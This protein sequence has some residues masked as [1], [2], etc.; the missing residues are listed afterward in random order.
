MNKSFSAGLSARAFSPPAGL[1]AGTAVVEVQPK[2]T[3]A[4]APP[5]PPAPLLAAPPAP[6]PPPPPPPAE[7]IRTEK[8]EMLT[9]I[10]RVMTG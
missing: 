9:N 1:T 6:L 2:P 8:R 3:A 5:A 4:P 10:V 7:G